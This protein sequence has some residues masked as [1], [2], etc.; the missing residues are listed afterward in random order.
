MALA[1]KE[2]QVNKNEI[3]NNDNIIFQSFITDGG[4]KTDIKLMLSDRKGS[5]GHWWQYSQFF[6]D[7]F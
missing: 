2:L 7:Y 3:N 6:K 5:K 4:K 1:A